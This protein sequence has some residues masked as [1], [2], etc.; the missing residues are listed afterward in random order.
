MTCTQLCQLAS[1]WRG[2]MPDG[3]L[4]AEPKMDGWRCLYFRGIDGKP[5]LWSRQG[6]PLDGADHVLHRLKLIEEAAGVELFIDG[7]IQVG[8]T[9]AAT[10]DWFERG[11]RVGGDRGTFHAFDVLDF[12]GWRAGGSDVPLFE[13]KARLARLVE[14]VGEP[15]DWRERSRGRDDPGC[16]Q[17]VPDEWAF[18][19]ADV[20]GIARRV[21]ATGG[22]GLMLKVA[23]APYR[24][25]RSDAWAKVKHENSRRWAGRI[26]VHPIAA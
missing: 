25:N 18:D 21:W 17:F 3:G 20:L 7:E 16:V 13:R 6:M 4:M 24:R 10:K 5:R 14:A 19:A 22:E 9:L 15:W 2:D 8:G 26:A 23:E 11:W 1:D 12:A